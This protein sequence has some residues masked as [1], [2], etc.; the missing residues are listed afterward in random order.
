MMH[1]TQH[2]LCTVL[3]P[4]GIVTIGSRSV[5][6][7]IPFK[8]PKIQEGWLYEGHARKYFVLKGEHLYEFLQR[9]RWDTAT[10]S[11]L[12]DLGTWDQ[13][14]QVSYNNNK[15]ALHSTAWNETKVFQTETTKEMLAWIR[16]IQAIQQNVKQPSIHFIDPKNKRTPYVNQ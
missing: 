11:N 5:N 2:R 7:S 1:V 10:A 16:N 14:K 3:K 9:Y 8:K 15:F 4:N 13:V 6:A 12:Y